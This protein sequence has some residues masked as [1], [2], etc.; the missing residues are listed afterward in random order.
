MF[1]TSYG[2]RGLVENIFL[3]SDSGAMNAGTIVFVW[4]IA[5]LLLGVAGLLCTT[6]T[7]T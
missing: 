6:G 5:L 2:Y 7:K 3:T 4:P 1:A